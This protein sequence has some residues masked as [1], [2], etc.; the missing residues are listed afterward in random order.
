M[1]GSAK[2]SPRKRLDALVRQAHELIAEA[3]RIADK[4]G[5]SFSV[6]FGSVHPGPDGDSPEAMHLAD[7]YEGRT[8]VTETYG[9]GD[10][11]ETHTYYDGGWMASDA[12]C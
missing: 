5:L 4:E 8:P 9:E 10:D 7:T 1:G 2:V 3:I 11:A 6:D 12:Y